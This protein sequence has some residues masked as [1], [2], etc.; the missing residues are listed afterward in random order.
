MNGDAYAYNTSAYVTQVFDGVQ[1]IREALQY[2]SWEN[3]SLSVKILE[4]VF[5]SLQEG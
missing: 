2:L 5:C 3:G 4:A 1:S